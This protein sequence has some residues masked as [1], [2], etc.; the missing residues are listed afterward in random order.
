MKNKIIK[1]SVKVVIMIIIA[2]IVFMNFRLDEKFQYMK[3]LDYQVILNQDGSMNVTETWDVCVNRTNTLV[4]NFDLSNR[5][6]DIT[7]VKVIDLEQGI[8]LKQIDKSMYH[9]TK[10]CYYALALTRYKFEI[11]WGVGL[12][13]KYANKKYQISYKVNNVMTEYKDLQEM[14][15]Q[16]LAKGKNDVPVS[17]I[18]GT[19][20]LPQDVNDINKLRVWGH[21]QSNGK[22]EK[23]NNHQVS[24]EM[25]NLNPK[26]RFEIRVVTEDKMFDVSSDKIRNYHY[27]DRIIQEETKWAEET[28]QESKK[29]QRFLV[30][31][32]GIYLI[33]IIV[34]VIKIRTY[35]RINKQEGDGIQHKN[36]QYYREI[37]RENDATPAEATYLYHFDKKRL[38]TKEIQSQVVASTILN[39]ALKKIISLSVKE[40]NAVYIKFLAEPVDLKKD[41]LAIYELLKEVSDE[42]QE[43]KLEGIEIYAK[44]EYNK[45]SG[46]VNK[47]VNTARDSLYDLKLIDKEKEKEYRKSEST[48]TKSLLVK[49]IYEWLVVTYMMSFLPIFRMGFIKEF[50]IGFPKTFLVGMVAILPIVSVL[51][52]TWKLQKD[53]SQKIAV[54]TQNGSNEKQEWKGLAN[55]MKDF[56]LLKE[57]EVP[58]LIIWEKY[59]V[60]ATA[61]G[62]ANKA[63]E[64]MKATYPKV[65]VKEQ[66]DDEKMAKQ[67]PIIYFSMNPMSYHN[68]GFN[69]ISQIN[70]S[71]EKAYHVSIA[72][73]VAHSSSSG[74][75]S[76]GGFSGGGGG[77][78]RPV[79]GMG[80]R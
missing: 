80:G 28:N 54:L 14:Y 9:V 30:V 69:P 40:G 22:I 45:Y 37:P 79:A 73:I 17:K 49:N 65:F 77:R 21:G 2:I 64:Q 52:Y 3:H 55:Y 67:Y 26:T 41:E 24:F 47:V 58:E 60:Y 16:F 11:A 68:S 1:L 27:L 59:L 42:Q 35:R 78:W 51:L 19:V 31:I 74:S 56:S 10:G 15:W 39:L 38:E 25:R 13:N 71:V 4:R 61:F 44:K 72:E 63:I 23:I 29:A 18:T 75:G 34:Q 32:A 8:E 62:I 50:G 36:L 43:F 57:K 53:A 46:F 70:S 12:E 33:I 20:T 5:F 66:W 7:D 76:G 6:G 48:E